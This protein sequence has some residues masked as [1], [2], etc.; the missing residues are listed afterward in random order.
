MKD[1]APPF[2]QRAA[3]LGL[4]LMGAS[5]GLALHEHGVAASVV[6][7]DTADAVAAAARARGAIA[8]V[9][10][11]VAAC[12]AGADLV[13]LATP[14]L[15]MRP[16]MAEMAPYLSDGTL[17]TDLGSTKAE[18]MRWAR[19]TLPP[20]VAFIGGHP[21]CGSERSGIEGATPALFHGAVWCL[22][23]RSPVEEVSTAR[24]TALIQRLGAHP[25]VVQAE[26]HDQ[27]V[28]RVS[29]LPLTVAATL[30]R[31]V[32]A[33]EDAA[34]ALSL[35]AGGLRDTTRVA[36]GSPI[37]AR[38][39]CLTNA[40]AL[41]TALDEHIALL[42]QLRGHIAAGDGPA[43][44]AQFGEARAARQAWLDGQGA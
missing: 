29:H 16:L 20:E 27:A 8:K 17:V 1:M 24:L 13:V 37:M 44:L 34:F 38:D 22:T 26:R 39:I 25:R 36:S 32:A 30:M 28:A 41:T 43:L 5:L 11:S 31:T 3:I 14:V 6:G 23:P 7:Y 2:V 42:R 9:A 10:R 35:A 21:M 15:A 33:H 12:V 40:A 18:V 19:A 4:G